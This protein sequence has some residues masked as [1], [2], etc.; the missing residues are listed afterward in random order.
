MSRFP[1]R[2]RDV[3]SKSIDG[4]SDLVVWA[5]IRDG[6]IDAFS[7]VT[8][9]TRLRQVAEALHKVRESAR[10]HELLEPFSDTA[11]RILSLLDF[12]IGIVER[13]LFVREPG[14]GKGASAYRPQRFMYLVATF[15]GPWEPYMRLI[16]RPLG[17]FL[18]LVLC[19]CE[20][21]KLAS[22][23]D[24][25]TYA[26]WV[27]DHQLDSAIFYSTSGLTVT[28]MIY[29]SDLEKIQRQDAPQISDPKIAGLTAPEPD[30]AASA[31]QEAYPAEAFRLALEALNVLYKLTDLYPAD[32]VNDP[33]GDGRLLLRAAR[34]LLGGYSFDDL[35]DDLAKVLA[36]VRP[37]YKAPLDWFG[38][39]VSLDDME[40]SPDPLFDPEEIQKGLLSSYD[41][42]EIL[43]THGALLLMRIDD[44]HKARNFL[45]WVE[46]DWEAGKPPATTGTSFWDRIY[47]NIFLTFRGLE[48]LGLTSYELSA[49]PKEFRQGMAERAPLLGDKFRNHPRRWKLPARNWP[50]G[51]G[52]AGIPVELAEID[53]AI[54]VRSGVSLRDPDSR[55]PDEFV[56]FG[57]LAARVMIRLGR[58]TDGE[59]RDRLKGKSDSVSGRPVGASEGSSMDKGS[60]EWRLEHFA[61]TYPDELASPV[62]VF[63]AFVHFLST[64]YGVSILGVEAMYRPGAARP[65]PA[66]DDPRV[67]IAN[68]V[69]TKDHFSFRDGIS[70]PTIVSSEQEDLSPSQVYAGDIVYGYRN[71]RGDY[72]LKSRRGSLLFNGSFLA[73]R[74]MSQNVPA[75]EAFTGAHPELLDGAKLV[76][77][78]KD[79]TPLVE[80]SASDNDFT[81]EKDP[82]G[83]RCPLSAH[84]RLAHPRGQFQDRKHPMILRRGMS[85]GPRYSPGTS[86]VPRGIVFMAFCSSLAEQYEVIQR[87]LNAGNPTGVSASQ[88]DPLTGVLPPDGTRTFR[89]LGEDGEIHRCTTQE[90]FTEL[91]WGHYFFC[92]S[93]TALKTLTSPR[94]PGATSL[95]RIDEGEAI[96]A[97][98]ESLSRERQQ[99]EWKR[100]LEDFLTKDPTEQDIC[101]RIC[102]AIEAR[103]GAY[104]IGSGV[105]FDAGG[106]DAAQPV[107]LVTD[108]DLIRNIFDNRC[109]DTLSGHPSQ[110]RPYS[111]REQRRR[112]SAEDACGTIYVSLDAPCPG[113]E[114]GIDPESQYFK[115]A[116]PTNSILLDY[117]VPASIR[118]GYEAGCKALAV[119]KQAA[120]T[121]ARL[122]GV[123]PEFKLELGRQFIHPALAE[124][125]RTWFGIP[126]DKEILAGGWDW[127]A[128]RPPVCPGDFLS[129]SRHAFY[130]RPSAAISKYGLRHGAALRRAVN[131]YIDAHWDDADPI[132]G[133][134]AGQMHRQIKALADAASKPEEKRFYK[135]LLGRNLIGIMIG[136]LPPMDANL[137]WTLFDWLD[138]DTLWRHQDRLLRH[139]DKGESPLE[140]IAEAVLTEPLSASMCVRPAPDLIYRLVEHEH[141]KIGNVIARKGDLVV[142]CLAGA[143][144]TLLKQEQA[145]VQLIFGGN[146]KDETGQILKDHPLHACPARDMAMG[147]MIGILAALL[148][149]G[150][151][152]ALPASLIVRISDWT[153]EGAP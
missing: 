49:F 121:L 73:V 100:V 86:D 93:K 4:I 97:E 39:D 131:D 87:W 55:I 129:P 84:I 85:Y 25:E 119:H 58:T 130:P 10:E 83:K 13:D 122:R 78:K 128:P 36:L 101:P 148:D 61:S 19:N 139:P 44:P 69:T 70:Q 9:E 77:R 47:K 57:D 126:N 68:S 98:I 104:R 34:S 21:Y 32:S 17:Y 123:R 138:R 43:V 67:P 102:E 106:P 41:S 37:L 8:Y 91:E 110:M 115:E 89:F 3:T 94:D 74:K 147:G 146:R 76:G 144:Q 79:G 48:R 38:Q 30:R 142:L 1:E 53:F 141:A 137:R 140:A 114:G 22:K 151:I 56:D 118:A 40:R 88:N 111:S 150:R 124:L 66:G 50:K 71:T 80:A 135:D 45:R 99:E 60:F 35:P 153:E 134:V 143:T 2:S 75:F 31:V 105:A 107:V 27:R 133:S 117:E 149:A 20:G 64:E 65:K 145:D 120:E 132:E 42:D 12:R 11:K 54:H 46:W 28:D 136:A 81:F 125:C 29:L 59:L 14:S 62:E 51:T 23:Y 24:F 103:G 33:D 109:V 18:D 92:P 95:V 82:E 72:H 15:D 26:K 113:D 108:P 52:P 63:V 96:I 127:S 90:S 116:Y 5:P 112:I 7:N 152:Q 6:F 16:W